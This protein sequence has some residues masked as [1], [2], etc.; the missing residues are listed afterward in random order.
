MRE[1]HVGSDFSRLP[2]APAPGEHQ[3]EQEMAHFIVHL[4]LVPARMKQSVTQRR[5]TNV[6]SLTW[7]T[8]AFVVTGLWMPET[9]LR[10][11]SIL[12]GK[13]NLAGK[14]WMDV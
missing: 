6:C 9:V 5:A 10:C 3:E 2:H 1:V 12:A 7:V 11:R 8:V 13:A 14:L 4:A